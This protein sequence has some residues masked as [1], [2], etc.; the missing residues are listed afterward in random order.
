MKTFLQSVLLLSLDIR[1]RKETAIKENM[2]F[3]ENVC[4]STEYIVMHRTVKP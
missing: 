4:S 1:K 3:Q 2:A